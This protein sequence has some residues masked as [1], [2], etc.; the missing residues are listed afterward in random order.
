M[1]SAIF[2][3]YSSHTTNLHNAHNTQL[4][5]DTVGMAQNVKKVKGKGSV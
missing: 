2:R 5:P 3:P 4:L 1:F